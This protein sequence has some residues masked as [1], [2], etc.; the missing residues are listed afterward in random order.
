MALC[1]PANY[2]E[3]E[4]GVKLYPKQREFLEAFGEAMARWAETQ[5]PQQI[6]FASCNE[7]G[8]TAI[9][10]MAGI[11]WV[12][13]MFPEGKVN[14]TS[15]SFRQ[16]KDQLR[17]ALARYENKYPSW[18]W[19]QEKI[20]TS[21][22]GF[23]RIYSTAQP[24]RAEGDHSDG[25]TRPLVCFV[26]EAKSVPVWLKGVIEGRVRPA[27]TVLLSSHGFSNGEWFHASQ[28]TDAAKYRVI[29]QT[30]YE[31]PHI[32][33]EVID[34]V[35]DDWKGFPSFADSILGLGFIPLV[36]DAVINALALSRLYERIH[37]VE[38]PLLPDEEN[39]EVHAFCDFA[40][41][42]DGDECCLALRRGNVVTLD[43]EC[44][45]RYDNLHKICDHFVAQFER[46][47]LKRHQIS[48]DEGS[49]GKLIMDELDRRGWRLKRVNNGATPKDTEHY[50]SV[51]AEMWYEGSKR[52]TSQEIILPD[53]I[54]LKQQLM[55]RK[56]VPGPKGKL[57]VESKID[58]KKRNVGSPDRAD[59]VLG[60]MMPVGGYGSFQG[61]SEKNVYVPKHAPTNPFVSFG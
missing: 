31:C 20:I 4:L 58:M 2:A 6:S 38:D 41:S 47:E 24:G 61:F 55:N 8:K 45:F 34:K 43:K 23:L 19:T 46:L 12:L 22:G 1:N 40:W 44:C 30:A 57:A 11:L 7:G 35:L 27:V 14:C 18:S 10:E 17:T 60:S 16:L 37:D 32:K 39:N 21:R 26:D 52:I 48:G 50:A 25:P 29:N 15:G 5:I 42:N 51:G 53:D 36:E 59:A 56:R 54:T 9:C 49:G 13:N 28:T 33:K 3:L